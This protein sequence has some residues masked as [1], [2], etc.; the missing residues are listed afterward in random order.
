[1]G[2]V[3]ERGEPAKAVRSQRGGRSDHAEA[4]GAGAACEGALLIAPTSGTP[5][6]FEDGSAIR[7]AT[8]PTPR[9]PS[10]QVRSY[11]TA[12][13]ARND[14]AHAPIAVRRGGSA[15]SPER[16]GVALFC[17]RSGCRQARQ[18]GSRR[19]GGGSR[20]GAARTPC[21]PRRGLGRGDGGRPGRQTAHASLL[22]SDLPRQN[23][24]V[25]TADVVGMVLPS[26]TASPMQAPYNPPVLPPRLDLD[27]SREGFRAGHRAGVRDFARADAP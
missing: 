1:M 7:T 24:P 6:T 15:R 9:L 18:N 12:T 25:P 22:W 16:Q 5:T 27:T 4:A 23:A 8:R 20:G 3:A 11:S 26:P 14:Q 19:R 10:I 2:C 13:R 17:Q 21:R